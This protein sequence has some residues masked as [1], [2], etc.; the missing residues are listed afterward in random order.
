[1]RKLAEGNTL[2]T[3]DRPLLEYHAPQTLLTRGLSDSNQ[4]LITQVRTGPLPANLAPSEVHNALQAGS[5][6]ALDLSD[7]ANAKAF[8]DA[9]ESQPESAGRYIAQGRFA[10]MQG[11][12][13]DAQSS[14]KAATKL[15]P[16][17]PE[18]MHWLA[19]VEHRSGDDTAARLLIEQ[20]LKRH[21]RFLPALDDEMQFAAD[22]KDF[23]AALLA[24]FSRMALIPDPPASEYCRLGAIWMKLSNLTEAEPV[25]LKGL[26]KD[27]YSYACHL[28]L[29]ELYRETTRFA[30][31][32]QHFEW[33]VRFFPDADATTF[34]SLAGVYVVLGDIASARSI[35][36]KGLRLFPEDTEL[37]NAQ[38]RFETNP[39]SR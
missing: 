9:L 2:N 26:L 12:L 33:V 13:P 32:R 21:P 10:L 25:L 8:L 6:T 22:R 7:A 17:S 31:A 30:L 5:A 35:L 39:P 36:R 3:D 20:I 28:E 15:D 38:A 14:L 29:G 1:V 37:Q 4:E 19:V 18:A 24:Q 16:D 11:A 34:R 27:P 23:R